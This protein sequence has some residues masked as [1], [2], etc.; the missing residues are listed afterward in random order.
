MFC[1]ISEYKMLVVVAKSI[2]KTR[3]ARN[4]D[5]QQQEAIIEG[6][7]HKEL[8]QIG[9]FKSAVTKFLKRSKIQG[10]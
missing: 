7:T 9:I 6:W 4:L 5:E 2:A 3:D 8:A 10:D 1:F